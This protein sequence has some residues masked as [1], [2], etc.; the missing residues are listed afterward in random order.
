VG[1]IARPNCF[2]FR[3]R[4]A[5]TRCQWP[6]YRNVLAEDSEISEAINAEKPQSSRPNLQALSAPIDF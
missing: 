1:E 3:G 5:W 2:G 4:R 6:S